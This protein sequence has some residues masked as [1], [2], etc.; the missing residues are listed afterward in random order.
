MIRLSKVKLINWMY[1]QNQTLTFG[2]NTVFA[3]VNGSGKSTI[4]DA[5]QMLFLGNK[6]SKFNSNANAEKR[7][8]E[9]YVRGAVTTMEKEFLR[10]GDVV[11]YLAMEV[12]DNSNTHLFGINIEYRYS[13]G[14]LS[15]PRYFYISNTSIT[16]ELFIENNFPRTY[17]NLIKNFKNKNIEYQTIHTL[18]AYQSKI[19]EVFGLKDEKKYF[20]TLSR[21]IG[22]K[23]ISDCNTFI[24]AFVLDE[25]PI[26]VSD[27]KNTLQSMR[28]LSQIIADEE[29]KELILNK[30]CKLYDDITIT[31]S[32]I[33]RNKV[34]IN[35][36]K[37]ELLSNENAEF[38][39]IIN[40]NE[41][42]ISDLKE[43]INQLEKENN[44]LL[45]RLKELNDRLEEISPNL[46]SK[47]K[48][49]EESYVKLD[50]ARTNLNTLNIYI[51]SELSNINELLSLG[52]DEFKDYRKYLKSNDFNSNTF[53]R[54]TKDYQL[55][56]IKVLDYYKTIQNELIKKIEQAKKELES[57][58]YQKKN[59]EA[60]RANIDPQ[61]VKFKEY[62]QKELSSKY[63]TNVEV[64][65]L[66]ECLDI[67]DDEWRDAIE[68]YLNK[69]RFYI[70]VEQKYFKETLR[71]YHSKKDFYLTNIIDSSKIPSQDPKEKT[72]GYYIKASNETALNYARYILNRVNTAN[73]INELNQYDIAITKDC[74][75]YQNYSVGRINP[76]FYREQY[77][78]EEGLKRT[79]K[80]IEAE[81]A[82]ANEEAIKIRDQ[83]HH[84]VLILEKLKT[85]YEYTSKILENNEYINSIDEEKKLYEEINLLEEEIVFY[86]NN[87][88]YLEITEK[89]S[90]TSLKLEDNK[91]LIANYREKVEQLNKENAVKQNM[92]SSNN[93]NIL[94]LFEELEELSVDDIYTERE[95]MHKYKVTKKEVEDFKYK[96]VKL[97]KS[98][99]EYQTEIILC[100]KEA[101]AH[102]LFPYEPSLK[103]I[104]KYIDEKNKIRTEIFE[105]KNNFID[106]Q[107]KI[108]LLFFDGFLSKLFNSIEDA[109]KNISN[110]NY[111]LS[112]SLFGSDFYVIKHSITENTDLQLIY[113]YAKKYNEDSERSLLNFDSMDGE[114]SRI[115]K[116]INDYFTSDDLVIREKIVDY[117]N[118]LDFDIHIHNNDNNTVKSFKKVFRVQSGGEVQVPFYILSAVAFH[119]TLDPRREG[120]AVV[121]Y[122][123]AFDKMDSQRIHAMLNFY[124]SLNIQLLM[125]MPGKLDSVVD[126]VETI[127]AICREGECAIAG[128]VTHELCE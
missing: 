79:L 68:G 117:R 41:A 101:N 24:S 107:T 78:G 17:D 57:L 9:S 85:T 45:I 13:T 48:Q 4:I 123:E 100:M 63:N 11:C 29:G 16:D 58:N 102:Y 80:I 92:I 46:T 60:K 28:K 51:S 42:K 108:R 33:L 36:M 74:M 67:S 39:K 128:D 98:L 49:L 127:Y 19:K 105:Y 104:N 52:V 120:L 53:K 69:Q 82:K 122:D 70:I 20:N 90:E 44:I 87:P 22:I 55:Q 25:N 31:E 103:D 91:N 65:F 110:L 43:M 6:A 50:V 111:A 119:Q 86:K 18:L 26:D 8:L 99:R 109:K 126:N 94:E 27:I 47:Q 77:I 5:I 10:P 93:E 125:A 71:L 118:Y 113:N 83:Y 61:L 84:M 88:K 95:R 12:E 64:K 2:G 1:F 106:Y 73:S 116:L 7:T 89:I 112:K 34:T 124:K 115:E 81:I 59:L 14:K 114:R 32:E 97:D 66:Y 40:L 30:I 121:L 23:N 15:D 72:L 75:R 38:S 96:N 56:T 54:L 35:L 62:L 37:T 21:A 76:K 3:G